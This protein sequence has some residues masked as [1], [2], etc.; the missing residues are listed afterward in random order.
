MDNIFLKK[1]ITYLI[2]LSFL[3]PLLFLPTLFVFPFVVPKV[4]FLR[5]FV[6]LAG[7][8][9]LLVWLIE[10]KRFKLSPLKAAVLF[11]FFFLSVS[12]ILSFD[13]RFSLWNSQERMLGFFTIAH[14]GILFLVCR[15]IFS[16]EQWKKAFKIF[17]SVAALVI[18]I[19]LI[20]KFFPEFF[21]NRGAR[22]VVSTLGNPI[23]LAGLSMY[24]FF[25]SL[26]WFLAYSQ[27]RSKFNLACAVLGVIGIFIAGTRGVFIGFVIALISGGLLYFWLVRREMNKKLR[28]IF[29]VAVL[30]LFIGTVSLFAF[31]KTVFVQNIPVVNRIVSISLQEG[32]AKTRIM[33]WQ[34]AWQGFKEKPLFGWGPNNFYYVFNKYYNPEFLK[35]GFQETWFDN[36]HNIVINILAEDG[37]FGLIGYMSL[38]LASGY[39]LVRVYKNDKKKEIWFLVCFSSFLLGHFIANLF[40]FENIVSYLYFFLMLG[41]VDFKWS[42]KTE[43]G[44]LKDSN[45]QTARIPLFL[46]IIFFVLAG[47]VILGTNVNTAAANNLNYQARGNMVILRDFERGFSLYKT[48]EKWRSPHQGDIDWEMAS[49]LL[50]ILPEAY[51][52]NTTTTRMYYDF[53]L[54]KMKNFVSLHPSDVRARLVYTDLLRA[55]IVLFDLLL[56]E[57]IENQFSIARELSP[58]RQQIDYSE[59]TFKAGIGD[60]KVAIEEMK[61]MTEEYPYAAEGYYNLARFLFHDGQYLE[62]LPVLD[63]AVNRGVFFTDP[64]HLE[65]VA[66]AYEREGRFK[67]SLFWWNQMYRVTGSESVKHKRD[68]LSQLT[69]KSIPNSLEEFFPFE[70]EQ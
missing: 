53:G 37:I 13:W 8:I 3:T 26:Y 52:A 56:K 17:N 55:G 64:V 57:E 15:S 34:S 2:Y 10:R 51:E 16:F 50:Q 63:K 54:E 5:S 41:F 28:N 22:Q 70:K 49:D 32:T 62:I 65:F 40:A 29:L 66:M 27:N 7:S 20:Q 48:T 6:I 35:F 43:Q 59:L 47:A 30:I 39:V 45:I 11:Y 12:T 24:L 9:T 21:Y 58:G 68:E 31:K 19:G 1:I 67:D 14:Y 69:K 38:F 60:I 44:E 61:K 23:Y 33:A 4:I 25:S 18:I 46:V 36:A 42:S